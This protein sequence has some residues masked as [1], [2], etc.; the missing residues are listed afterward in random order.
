MNEVAK[1]YSASVISDLHFSAE[2]KILH[3]PKI[4][5]KRAKN[6]LLKKK[7]LI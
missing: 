1:M 2:L 6:D 4:Q 3:A 7:K 5:I